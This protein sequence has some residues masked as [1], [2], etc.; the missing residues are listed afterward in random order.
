M[1][2]RL[3]LMALAA[4]AAGCRGEDPRAPQTRGDLALARLVDS[5][6]A[7]VEQATGLRFTEPPRSAMR[8]REQVRAYLI[9]K[10]DEEL[11]P[12]RLRGLETAYRLF[13]LLPDTLQLRPLLL[14]LYTEQVAGFYDP[15]SA[16]LFGVECADRTQLRLV[17]A[18]ELIHALQGQHLPL[19]SIL[20]ARENND[21]L[22]AAPRAHRPSNRGSRSASVS[23]HC[24]LEPRPSSISSRR[25]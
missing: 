9:A 14:D 24:S 23:S 25:R 3:W 19:D 21:R 17:L 4:M 2:R 7:P 5:L 1:T 11:P 16:T 6:R 13:G 20:D 12:E 8:S 10:L 15:D 22:T 18:H